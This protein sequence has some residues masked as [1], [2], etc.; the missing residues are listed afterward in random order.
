[1]EIEGRRL[2]LAMEA[3]D[4]SRLDE[5][6]ADKHMTVDILLCDLHRIHKIL[7][8][9]EYYDYEAQEGVKA[10]VPPDHTP[11]IGHIGI[12]QRLPHNECIWGDQK[13]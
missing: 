2:K 1:M 10:L 5:Q 6:H 12:S 7:S 8:G 11:R 9:E 3:C 4:P 13:D